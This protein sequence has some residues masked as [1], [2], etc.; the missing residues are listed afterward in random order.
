MLLN[1]H[2]RNFMKFREISCF[3][4]FSSN[5]AKLKI[6]L[7][8]YRE[9]QNFVKIIFDF[10]EVRGKFRENEIKNFTKIS[11]NYK[12]EILQQPYAGVE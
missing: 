9:T 7:S 4:K 11:R 1:F 3:A 12:N 10:R 8:K 6:I 5:F 2:F